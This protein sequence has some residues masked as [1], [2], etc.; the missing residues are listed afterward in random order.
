MWP[1]N[2]MFICFVVYARVSVEALVFSLVFSVFL[3]TDINK[4]S[5]K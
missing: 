1:E 5:L 2:K 4:F 3:F